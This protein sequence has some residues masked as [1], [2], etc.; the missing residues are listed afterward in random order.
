MMV[1]FPLIWWFDFV[2]YV[3]GRLFILRIAFKLY[4]FNFTSSGLEAN[5]P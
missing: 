4:R 3:N 5:G 1:A 2:D